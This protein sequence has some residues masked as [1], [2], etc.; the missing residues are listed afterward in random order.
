MPI[1][2]DIPILIP[3]S[4]VLVVF[5]LFLFTLFI[6]FSNS[7]DIVKMSQISLDIGD[8]IITAH[9][10]ISTG[11]GMLN[12]TNLFSHKYKWAKDKC[13]ENN[14][15]HSYIKYLSNISAPY[16]L[17]IKIKTNKTCWCWGEIKNSKDVVVN[18]F[19]VLIINESKT[20]PGVVI[21]SV[22]K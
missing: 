19:P 3:I 6:N 22:G 15:T 2:E 16:K 8:Y 7:T 9:P 4:I 11:L 20:I 21:V 5:L 12:G 13:A 18:N 1:G 14:C 10:N 17:S